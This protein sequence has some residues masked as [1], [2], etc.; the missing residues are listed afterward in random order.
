MNSAEEQMKLEEARL[1]RSLNRDPFEIRRKKGLTWSERQK[2]QLQKDLAEEAKKEEANNKPQSLKVKTPQQRQSVVIGQPSFTRTTSTFTTTSPAKTPTKPGLSLSAPKE[3]KDLKPNTKVEQQNGSQT[4]GQIDDSSDMVKREEKRLSRAFGRNVT[5]PQLS[6]NVDTKPKKEDVLAKLTSTAKINSPPKATTSGPKAM[7]ELD[8]LLSEVNSLASKMKQPKPQEEKPKETEQT[9]TEKSKNHSDLDEAYDVIQSI[10]TTANETV[11]HASSRPSLQNA[12]KFQQTSS[13]PDISE[14]A[15]QP[16][17]RGNSNISATVKEGISQMKES[18]NIMKEILNKVIPYAQGFIL[19]HLKTVITFEAEWT[20]FK[21]SP[22]LVLAM[23]TLKEHAFSQILDSIKQLNETGRDNIIDSITKIKIFNVPGADLNQKKL[24]MNGKSL[25]YYG[26]FEAGVDGCYS[27]ADLDAFFCFG[28]KQKKQAVTDSKKRFDDE[29]KMEELKKK[30]DDA[31]MQMEI[32]IQ[33]RKQEADRKQQLLDQERQLEEANVLLQLQ[34]EDER[35]KQVERERRQQEDKKKQE[36]STRRLEEMEKLRQEEIRKRREEE[37]KQRQMV[38]KQNEERDLASLE[39]AIQKHPTKQISDE[40][41]QKALAVLDNILVGLD[42]PKHGISR[43]VSFQQLST[44]VSQTSPDDLLNL[45]PPQPTF[46]IT[47]KEEIQ[48]EKKPIQPVQ[49]SESIEQF[50]ADIVAFGKQVTPL[51]RVS[52]P[53]D[54]ELDSFCAVVKSLV[55]TVT[56]RVEELSLPASQKDEIV[57]VM[58]SFAQAS[59]TFAKISLPICFSMQEFEEASVPVCDGL[60][61]IFITVKGIRDQPS[62]AA[63]TTPPPQITRSEPSPPSEVPKFVKETTITAAKVVVL[64][65]ADRFDLDGFTDLISVLV[66]T[67]R[68]GI[69]TF[70]KDKNERQALS[71]KLMILLHNSI[72]L[73]NS[74]GTDVDYRRNLTIAMSDVM[75]ALTTT[76]FD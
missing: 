49:M 69:N 26:A 13:R 35:K 55:E 11:V 52:R 21:Q 38:L 59:H 48:P 19:E 56:K 18:D 12:G 63:K 25:F 64:L 23:Q 14:A 36:E 44:K 70:V 28:L 60:R 16:I 4:I 42:D 8:E 58:K 45:I 75:K 40:D 2:Q 74:G 24:Q 33:K 61:D 37:D 71:D 66:S 54:F 67:V 62:S 27:A 43:N 39:E 72:Q 3:Q 20:T 51:L 7:E 31:R 22:L 57:Y 6:V 5:S 15:K 50:C 68:N 65:K 10:Q 30:E 9:P 46:P 17:Q 1:A 53:R 73:K 76:K 34:K 29:K 41:K 32:D 47:K